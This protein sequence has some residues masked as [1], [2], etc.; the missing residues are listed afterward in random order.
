MGLIHETDSSLKSSYFFGEFNTIIGFPEERF[1]SIRGVGCK[2]SW[3]RQADVV[4][5]ICPQIGIT[6]MRKYGEVV[7]VPV[8]T[9]LTSS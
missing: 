8:L 1:I 4:G 7:V 3:W 2:I 5:I 6:N 9:T